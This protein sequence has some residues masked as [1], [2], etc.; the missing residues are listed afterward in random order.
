MDQGDAVRRIF[1]AVGDTLQTAEFGFADLSSEDPQRR[2]AGLR[3]LVVFGRAVTN[4]LQ[5]L[6]TPLGDEFEEWYS[7]VRQGLEDDALMR[8]FYKLR[9][10]ILKEGS[11]ASLGAYTH[12]GSFSSTDMQRL[13][14]SAPPGAKAF[15][16]GDR[17]GGD[18]WEVE[19]GDG[20]TETYYVTLPGDINA[21][22]SLHLSDAPAEHQG[23]QIGDTS[24]EALAG[25]YLAYLRQ[26][27]A[28]ARERFSA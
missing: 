8:Y 7:S 3:N 18:G 24:V 28:E 21:T 22:T 14:E 12:V 17:L 9:S 4:V 25:R 1:E 23:E 16:M 20:T 2:V 15:F 26:L 27:V 6:K 13:R 19:M 10:E 5:K 11:I